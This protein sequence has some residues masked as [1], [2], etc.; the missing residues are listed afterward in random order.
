MCSVTGETGNGVLVINYADGNFVPP[1]AANYPKALMIT[2]HDHSADG[3]YRILR[4]VLSG[5]QTICCT[6]GHQNIIVGF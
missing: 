4:F 2:A 6:G 1:K 3:P 5:A